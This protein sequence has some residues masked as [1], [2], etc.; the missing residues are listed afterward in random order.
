MTKTNLKKALR[1]A[2][3]FIRK[4]KLLLKEEDSVEHYPGSALS[5]SVRRSSLDLAR[6]LSELRKSTW[7]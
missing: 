7:G 6:A 3:E 2:E 5:G 4:A 1:E